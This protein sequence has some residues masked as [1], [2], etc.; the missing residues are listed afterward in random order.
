MLRKETVEPRTLELLKQLMQVAELAPFALLGGTSLA[1]RWGHRISEDLDLFSNVHFNEDE[2]LSALEKNFNDIIVSRQEKQTLGLFVGD[3]KIE[4]IS[5]KRPYLKPFEVIEDIRFFS[6]EDTMAFKM[7]AVERRGSKK[8]FYDL[9]EALKHY[10]FSDIIGF[11]KQKFVTS[12]IGNLLKS[13]TYFED[14]END[15]E[16]EILTPVS[17]AKVKKTILKEFDSYIRQ[18]IK[19]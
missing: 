17:W 3:V 7:N 16:F 12:D 8:D 5:P 13:L 9:H 1:L 11:Y 4:I 18:A 2:V 15:P 6:V 14:A 10:P 19:K